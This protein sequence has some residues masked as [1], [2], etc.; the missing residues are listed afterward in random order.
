MYKI[1]N[2]FGGLS[3][4]LRFKWIAWYIRRGIIPDGVPLGEVYEALRQTKPRGVLEMFGFLHYRIFRRDGLR[5]DKAGLVSAKLVTTAFANY[6]VDELQAS[7]ANFSNFMYHDQG[8]DSTA[9]SNSHTALQNS[10][11]TRVSGSQTENGANRYKSVGNITATANYTAEEHGIFN[12]SSAGVMLDRNLPANAP[13]LEVDDTVEWT[14]E[15]LVN[16]ES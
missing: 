12:E 11:E 6:L 7:N 8:D 15:L 1:Q 14:Y 9:E 13:V 3:R 5:I 10:M 16:A 2:W 4:S